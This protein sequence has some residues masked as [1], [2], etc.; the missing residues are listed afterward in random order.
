[1]TLIAWYP[2]SAAKLDSEIVFYGTLERFL[3]A[4]HKIG[5]E[6]WTTASSLYA[7]TF[8]EV[9]LQN[10]HL[11]HSR[12]PELFYSTTGLPVITP[13]NYKQ[14]LSMASG[15]QFKLWTWFAGRS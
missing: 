5:G 3:G 4:W 14:F 10:L 11:E 13:A 8:S 2:S 7:G 9:H 1:M 12:L 15:T 6:K